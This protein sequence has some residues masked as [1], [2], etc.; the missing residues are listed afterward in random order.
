MDIW[1][2]K[3]NKKLNKLIIETR[4]TRSGTKNS[5]TQSRIINLTGLT[6]HKEHVVDTLPLGHNYAL[7][8]KNP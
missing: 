3:L 7:E 4:T 8:T 5:N 1:Y 2:R 6:L